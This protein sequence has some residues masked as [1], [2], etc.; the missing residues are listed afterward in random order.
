M[1]GVGDPDRTNQSSVRLRTGTSSSCSRL[2]KMLTEEVTD[3][4]GCSKPHDRNINSY[5]HVFLVIVKTDERFPAH[6]NHHDR[7]RK[8]DDMK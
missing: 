2:S 3:V 1:S 4:D 6:S 5:M 8:K 7:K